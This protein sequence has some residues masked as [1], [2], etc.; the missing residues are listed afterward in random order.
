MCYTYIRISNLINIVSFTKVQ[1][2]E[3]II[4]YAHK[5]QNTIF[6]GDE[7]QT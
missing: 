3:I 5:T 7:I 2:P 6:D 4:L 1:F